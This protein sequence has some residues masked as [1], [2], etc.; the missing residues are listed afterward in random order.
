MKQYIMALDQGTTSSRCILFNRKGQPVSMAQREF[1]QIYPKAGWVEQNP[2]EIWSSQASVAT[3]AMG[4]LGISVEE[5]AGIGITNQRETTIVWDKTTGKPIYNAIVWQC[6]R[7]ADR[8]K[9]LE[10]DGMAE[11]IREHTGLVPDAYFSASKLAWIL[12]HVDGA[13]ERARKGELLFGTVDT[14]LIWNLTKGAV[15]VTDYTNASRTMLFDIHKLCWDKK[16]LDYFDIPEGMLPQVKP[17]SSIYGY[18]K[19]SVLGGEVPIAG[20]AGDQ[21]AA[22]F[23]QC[24]FERGM[25]KNTYGTG[26]FILMNTG[27]EA[28]VSGHGLLTTI[29]ASLS[30]KV[31]YALEGSVFVAGAAIQ[32][33]RDE[34]RLVEDAAVTERLAQSVPDSNGVYVVPAFTGLGAP[35]WNPYARGA[36]FGITRGCS[37]A[38]F[39]RAALEAIAYETND[40][41]YAMEEDLGQPLASLKVDGGASANNFLLQFQSDI[42]KTEVERPECVETTALG[43]AYLAGLA[44]GFFQSLSDIQENWCLDRAFSPKMEESLRKEKLDGWKKAVRCALMWTE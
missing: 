16:I 8:I 10:A 25:V 33:L 9:Q 19:A 26:S 37:K 28:V 3:E 38:H 22:L 23:G 13:R 36:V 39:V 12:E 43:A 30:D 7:T 35:Y 6:R 20:A 2:R 18:T 41:I 15:F 4:R 44:T 14:W 32:W 5:L 31:D 29:A 21:Q 11:Y 24:C 42:T 27:R 34:M 40:V 17:S 1:E